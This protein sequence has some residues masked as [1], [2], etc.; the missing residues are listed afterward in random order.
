MTKETRIISKEWKKD[1]LALVEKYIQQS[2]LSTYTISIRAVGCAQTV[3]KL[4]KGSNCN[5]NTLCK[6][7]DWLIKHINEGE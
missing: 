2:G 1:I 4:Y 7:E 5:A 6:L 3:P